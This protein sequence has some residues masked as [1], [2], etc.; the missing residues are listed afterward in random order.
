MCLHAFA[1]NAVIVWINLF[2]SNGTEMGAEEGRFRE[3]APTFLSAGQIL[4]V[5][6]ETVHLSLIRHKHR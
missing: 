4:N 5:Q 1:S 2:Y 3:I 6:G